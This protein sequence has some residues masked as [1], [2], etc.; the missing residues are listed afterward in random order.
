MYNYS[1]L[2]NRRNVCVFLLD[3]P[4]IPPFFSLRRKKKKKKEKKKRPDGKRPSLDIF[5]IFSIVIG[6]FESI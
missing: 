6:L 4:C 2:Q 3:N 1:T 5:V